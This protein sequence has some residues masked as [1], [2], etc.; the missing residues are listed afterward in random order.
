MFESHRSTVSRALT[1][2]ILAAFA[3]C[4]ADTMSPN[5]PGPP[6]ELPPLTSMSGDFSIFGNAGA[7][8]ADV[9]SELSMSSF[10]FTTAAIRVLAAQVVTVA[11][12]AVPVAT[13]AAAANSTPTFED[14]DRWH[15][16]FTTVQGGHTYTAHLSGAVQGNTVGW[17]MRITSPTHSPPLEEFVWYGGQGL[18]DRTS[19]SWTFYDPATPASST[20]VLRIDW[21]HVSATEHGW[22]AT[23]LSGAASGDVFTA[24]VDGDDR[25]ITYLDASAQE[26]MEI[27][28]NAADGSGYLIGPHYNGGV[29]ACWDT[30]QQDIACGLRPP[31]TRACAGGADQAPPPR[32]A[33]GI[34]LSA[35]LRQPASAGFGTVPGS[36]GRRRFPALSCPTMAATAISPVTFATVRIMSGMRSRAM[37]IPIPSMGRPNAIQRGATTKS[38]PLGI[39]GE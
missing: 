31:A 27:Y 34:T 11:A 33:S 19:G 13:F 7:Q 38:P 21:T 36:A 20:A 28:W 8:Q 16:R 35:R 4:T 14:D 12:L 39:P 15:W 18:R 1:L 9:A 24:S 37:R 26:L 22:E 5:D 25:M 29:K 32:T 17:D 23:A 10:H 3:A 30:N 6:P 2:A